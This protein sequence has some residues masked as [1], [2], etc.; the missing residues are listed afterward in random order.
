MVGRPPLDLGR[1]L[2]HIVS[3]ILWNRPVQHQLHGNILGKC[4]YVWMYRFPV[5]S[6]RCQAFGSRRLKQARLN[7][8]WTCRC[9]F[10]WAPPA[11][12]HFSRVCRQSPSTPRSRKRKALHDAVIFDRVPYTTLPRFLGKGPCEIRKD[13]SRCKWI[14]KPRAAQ[15]R[16]SYHIG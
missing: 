10:L 9:W 6:N 1:Q 2:Q 12:R 5:F 11:A 3:K 15:R 13:E 7:R 16:Q 14:H 4:V 8:R